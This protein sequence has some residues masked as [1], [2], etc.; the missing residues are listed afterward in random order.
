[1][2]MDRRT[3]DSDPEE[4][5]MEARK[6][7]LLQ[8]SDWAGLVRP[9]P[10]VMDFKAKEDR[11][12]IGKRRKIRDPHALTIP[13][14]HSRLVP[15]P[16][17]FGTSRQ[18]GQD[19]SGAPRDYDIRIRIGTDALTRDWTMQQTPSQSQAAVTS[20]EASSNSMLMD[21]EDL[22]IF[23]PKPGQQGHDPPRE[24]VGAHLHAHKS[25]HQQT[26]GESPRSHQPYR[27]G[28]SVDSE[29]PG[30]KQDLDISSND[31]GRTNPIDPFSANKVSPNELGEVPVCYIAQQM[32]SIARP[33]RLTFDTASDSL[34]AVLMNNASPGN[35]IGE[36]NHDRVTA[37]AASI[38]TGNVQIEV[39]AGSAGARP[40]G[41]D[42]G[43]WRAFLPARA[44]SSKLSIA[45]DS[46]AIDR[47]H[48]RPSSVPSA[49]SVPWSQQATQDVQT[50]VN[51]SSG[52]SPSLPSLTRESDED[53]LRKRPH[54][55]TEVLGRPPKRQ[56]NEDDGFWQRLVFGNDRFEPTD[57]ILERK[58]ILGE[59]HTMAERSIPSSVA[60]SLSF[61]TP[62]DSLCG[63]GSC[64]SDSAQD[65]T[66]RAPLATSSG[67]MLPMITSST[68]PLDGR[69]QSI[70]L[71]EDESGDRAPQS[72]EDSGFGLRSVTHTS[73]QNNV[74]CNSGASLSENSG[75]HARPS[76]IDSGGVEVCRNGR[77]G[78]ARANRRVSASIY[79]IPVSSDDGDG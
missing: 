15:R 53:E 79:D 40:S 14:A 74:S 57:S 36:P 35:T 2:R 73:M 59:M 44:G 24:F 58:V 70:K 41:I 45:E 46:S 61:T 55:G 1:M 56:C 30:R 6:K 17:Q 69:G 21:N 28:G 78:S 3:A 8:Q 31:R 4:S 19:T 43:P 77:F 23:A 72:A 37:N 48:D 76:G 68:A 20:Y 63:P 52:V 34:A 5:L 75:D 64:V 62:F 18:P 42:D 11:G 38:E 54:M 39:E 65:A 7:R 16:F 71:S 29:H 47:A 32:E 12:K 66:T 51:L 25:L 27:W 13:K 60:V 22:H 49:E 50:L 33:L 67:S 9:K 10:A 26:R